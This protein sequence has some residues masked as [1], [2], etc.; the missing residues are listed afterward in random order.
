MARELF[1]PHWDLVLRAHQEV[2]G[3]EVIFDV[4]LQRK[5]EQP[6]KLIRAIA[7]TGKLVMRMWKT[8]R[9]M[10]SAILAEQVLLAPLAGQEPDADPPTAGYSWSPTAAKTQPAQRDG[11]Q[12]AL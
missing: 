9:T 4:T 12:S 6:V 1:E 7:T 8:A 11:E 5:G 10:A 3:G 2:A